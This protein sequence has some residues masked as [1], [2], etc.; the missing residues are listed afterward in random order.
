M[1][2][3]V[4]RCSLDYN[5]LEIQPCENMEWHGAKVAITQ[6]RNAVKYFGKLD[7]DGAH[8]PSHL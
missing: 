5:E 6:L 8:Q 7:L 3:S 1:R 2:E 4:E